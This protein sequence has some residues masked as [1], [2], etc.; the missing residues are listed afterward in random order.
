MYNL[1]P[2]LLILLFAAAIYAQADTRIFATWRVVRYD[3]KVTVSAQ[4]DRGL[5]ARATL[6]LKNVSASSASTVTLRISSAALVTSASVS[7]SPAAFTKAED[8]TAGTLLQRVIIPVPPTASGASANVTVEYSLPVKENTGLA[9]IA[10]DRSQFLP[11]SFWYPTPNSWYF[12]RGADYAPVRMTIDAAGSETVVASGIQR[13]EKAF[14]QP[15]NIQPFFV[16]GG[17]DKRG[18]G[19]H[20]IVYVPKGSGEEANA[21]STDL[22]VIAAESQAFIARSLGPAPNAPIQIVAVGRGGGFSGGG[23]LLLDAAVFRRTKIDS[24]TALSVAETVAKMWLGGTNAVVGDGDG[25]IREGVARY[26]ATQFIESKYGKDVADVERARQRAAYSGIATRDAPITL[27]SPMSDFYYTE[28]ANKGAMIWRLIAKKVGDAQFSAL[29]KA[30]IEDKSVSLA[31]LREA[32]G[33]HKEFLDYGFD[34]VTDMNLQAGLPQP[35][36]GG[37]KVALRNTG[38]V[39]ATVNVSVWLAN[40]EQMTAQSTVRA[41]SFGEVSFITGSK[42]DRVEIDSEKLYP[43]L[44]YSDDVA[45]RQYTES[46]PLLAVK[47]LFD[48]QDFVAA[49]RAAASVLRHLPRFDDVRIFLGRSL[50]A[51]GRIADAEREF[52]AVLNEKLPSA[53]SLAWANV[54]LADAAQRTGKAADAARMA[55]AAIRAD[56]DYGASLAAR[57]IRR[58]SGT[59]PQPDEEIKTY[60]SRFDAAASANRKAELEDLVFPGEVTRFTN[61]ISGQTEQWKTAIVAVDRLD[62]DTLLVETEM[63]IKLLN[64]ELSTGL[65]VY[66]LRKGGQGWKL[67]AVDIFEVL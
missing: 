1:R 5:K 58:K 8:R 66:R 51:Q 3:L 28:V 64:R 12:A 15:L 57:T 47:R 23:T 41:K 67:S 31:E 32:L 44:D 22:A 11:L 54:G 2:L 24:Q 9:S 61:G 21:M 20:A 56:G 60:F 55:A 14:E 16:S 40:G 10:A 27:V 17:W 59:M 42:V 30:A 29:L 26:L 18:D 25:A 46:D 35:I 53:R 34:Q 38:S 52:N 7:G 13:G 50:L 39:D 19:K 36:A 63:S 62:A 4:T 37:W 33:S 45:P 65:A 49:E 48:K 6:D 43:Q